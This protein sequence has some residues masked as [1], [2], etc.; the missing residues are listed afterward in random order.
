MLTGDPSAVLAAMEPTSISSSPPQNSLDITDAPIS[1]GSSKAS[2]GTKGAS[3]INSS[4]SGRGGR[5]ATIEA[6]KAAAKQPAQVRIKAYVLRQRGLYFFRLEF[7]LTLLSQGLSKMAPR[8][9]ELA[10]MA[11]LGFKSY[12]DG[13]EGWDYEDWDEEGWEE[14]W[15]EWEEEQ[16]GQDVDTAMPGVKAGEVSMAVKVKA[17][18]EAIAKQATAGHGKVGRVHAQ[19]D[20]D[21]YTTQIKS[22]V[23][24]KVDMDSMY[25][26]EVTDPLF[27]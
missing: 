26:P 1:T 19:R 21:D 16:G 24:A 13:Q 9:Y 17:A 8:K 20:T 15:E 14:G 25:D 11:D 6:P 5:G 3:Q 4:K 22:T 2:S 27:L 23:R 7:D 12:T 10:D 18:N